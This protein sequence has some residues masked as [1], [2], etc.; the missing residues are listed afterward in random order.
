MPFDADIARQIMVDSQVRPNDVTDPAIQDAMRRVAR[1]AYCGSATHLAY[2][3]AEVEY[4]PG[5]WLLR[6]RDV[7]KLLQAVRPRAG[8]KALAI[9]APYVAA[10]LEQ[11]GLT[12]ARAD[13][14]D[15]VAG[16]YDVI[17]CEGGVEETPKAWL[18]ALAVGGR[19]AVIE[20]RGAAGAAKLYIRSETDLGGRSVFDAAPPVLAGLEKRASF[21]F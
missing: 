15:A 7:S 17:V 3:D 1:E 5:R 4:A 6:P 19:L 8:E 10:L 16:S 14:L 11:I 2:A 21:A 18:D 13:A 12:V 9:S 20:R